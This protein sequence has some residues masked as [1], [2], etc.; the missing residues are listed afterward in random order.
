MKTLT[1]ETYYSKTLGCWMGKNAGGTL[2]GPD[3]GKIGPLSLD[4][5][6]VIQEGGIPNDDLEIQLVWLH[7]L[8]TRGTHLTAED[9]GCEWLDHYLPNWAEYGFAKTNLRKG[10]LP[11]LSGNFN[12]WFHQ[13]MGCPIRSEIW[14]CVAP[15]LP[16]EA[17]RMA[18]EDAV[19]DHGPESTYAEILFAVIESAAFLESDRDKLVEL[20]LAAIPDD[21][22][23]ARAVTTLL[24]AWAETKDWKKTRDAILAVEGCDADFTDAPQN[25]AFTL[26]GWYSSPNDFGKAIC[27][28]VNCGYDTDCTGATLG[29]I[30]GI[31]W[32]AE[33]MPEK[34]MKPLGRSLA[35]DLVRTRIFDAPKTVDDLT[36]RT[37]AQS[38]AF[39]AGR[40]IPFGPGKSIELSLPTPTELRTQIRAAG[41]WDLSKNTIERK[42]H[43]AKAK[44]IYEKNPLLAPGETSKVSVVFTN[45]TERKLEGPV[46][47]AS[48]EEALSVTIKPGLMD[49]QAG[50]SATFEV[51]AMLGKKAPTLGH[52]EVAVGFMA[53]GMS[54]WT[55]PISFVRPMV[56]SLEK[57]SEK[58]F[59]A[60]DFSSLTKEPKVAK[61][62]SVSVSGNIMPL[63]EPGV[64]F[65]Q[66]RVWNPSAHSRTVRLCTPSHHSVKLWLNGKEAVN[67][68]GAPKIMP[69][70]HWNPDFHYGSGELRP[71]W[72]RL[73][74]AWN[75][76]SAK[77]ETHLFLTTPDGTGWGDLVFEV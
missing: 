38:M 30:L 43:H 3:E 6:P 33:R 31:A 26:L 21:C 1:W 73:S 35:T 72:N 14:A 13:S 75:I 15:G 5:Y 58:E 71:G 64:W 44:I 68:P 28:A 7:A 22:R 39:F 65:G 9:L 41:L 74:G 76:T 50:Q 16:L 56:W 69:S 40:G 77:G 20:G 11:P 63:K 17:A 36:D 10:L 4:W 62:K 34:W 45:T 29:S 52:V 61:G 8:E 70:Y 53:D 48:F 51:T 66:T 32:G 18:R 67:N 47:V 37:A 2:G 55:F 27:D 54:P 57:K 49:V 42:C 19:V 12:N 24:R 60:G 59:S 23:T 46:R 25:I